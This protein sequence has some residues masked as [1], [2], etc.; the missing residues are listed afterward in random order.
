VSGVCGWVRACVWS[1]DKYMAG[2]VGART[3]GF[4][5]SLFESKNVC[6]CVCSCSYVCDCIS[7]SLSLCLWVGG[8]ACARVCD[9]HADSGQA[10]LTP[11]LVFSFIFNFF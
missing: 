1:G 7:L 11:S 8:W 4:V 5:A 9:Y 10:Q 6:V 3:P 2:F